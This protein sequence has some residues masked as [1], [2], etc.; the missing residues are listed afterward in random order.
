VA[1][2]QAVLFELVPKFEKEWLPQSLSPPNAL[3]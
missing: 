2:K 3:R 1:S